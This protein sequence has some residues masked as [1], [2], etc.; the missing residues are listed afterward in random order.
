MTKTSLAGLDVLSNEFGLQKCGVHYSVFFHIPGKCWIFLVYVVNI[1][2]TGDDMVGIHELKQLVQAIQHLDLCLWSIFSSSF[3]FHSSPSGLF[4]QSY[5]DGIFLNLQ[6]WCVN[7]TVLAGNTNK[8]GQSTSHNPW[9][10]Y[11]HIS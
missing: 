5:N 7:Q 11:S 8:W 4:G 3:F 10:G 2:I 6:S 9:S 1:V